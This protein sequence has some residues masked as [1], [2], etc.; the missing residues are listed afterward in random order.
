MSEDLIHRSE[1]FHPKKLRR[2]ANVSPESFFELDLRSGVITS[3][4]S[5]PEMNKPSYKIEV[6]FGPVTGRLWSSAQICNYEPEELI[7]KSVVGV[8]NI[9]QKSLPTGFL[10]HFLILAALDPDGTARLLEVPDGI[11]C[12]SKIA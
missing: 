3:V 6:D 8:L 5:I 9:G 7:G 4:E 11:E 12:G 10:S 2:K 1:P